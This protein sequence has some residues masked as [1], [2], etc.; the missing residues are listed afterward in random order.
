MASG[1]KGQVREDTIA[2]W[3]FMT[4]ALIVFI[5]FLIIPIFFAI[6][7]SFTDW[8]G[9]SPP[10]EASW[11]GTENYE[12]VLVGGGI[13][14]SDFFKALKN[15]TY[16]ALGVVPLQTILSL[17]RGRQPAPTALQGFLSHR[18]LLP[19]YHVL[20]SD[21]PHLSVSVPAKRIGESYVGDDNV[22]RL[23]ADCLD[24]GRA[25]GISHYSGKSGDYVARWSPVSAEP[26]AG[27]HRMGLD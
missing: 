11:V 20:C 14:Q 24:G 1:I 27:S 10:T 18:L 26:G 25:R 21:Q 2:G 19:L 12:E 5:I 17:C 7:F 15:T 8:N 22:W 6:Y 13:R 23:G 9:I 3:L 16:F 4:P